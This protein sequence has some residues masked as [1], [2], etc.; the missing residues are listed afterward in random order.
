M[1]DEADV[2]IVN[3]CG[4]IDA[5]KQES[6]DA[7][8]QAGRYKTDGTC[9]AVVAV[10]CLIQRHKDELAKALPEVDLFLG[11]AETD[12]L[13]PELDGARTAG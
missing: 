8:V 10:G 4:F 9:Q 3:T 13:I 6:I 7:I 5:A 12:R 1:L 11:A 2:I